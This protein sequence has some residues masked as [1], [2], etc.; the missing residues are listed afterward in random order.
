M[1]EFLWRSA[2]LHPGAPFR[3][4]PIFDLMNLLAE[5]QEKRLEQHMQVPEECFRVSEAISQDFNDFVNEFA[6]P[7]VAPEAP[8]VAEEVLL[9]PA[10]SVEEE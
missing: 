10:E 1:A 8:A 3:D 5:F 6:H 9:P 4:A 7:V 2:N